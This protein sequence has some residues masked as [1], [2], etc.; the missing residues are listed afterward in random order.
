MFGHNMLINAVAF[1]SDGATLAASAGDAAIRSDAN[2]I[3]IYMDLATAQRARGIRIDWVDSVQGSGLSIDNPNAPAAVKSLTV[4]E[5][6]ARL[7][8]G[9][10]TVID[11]RP[12]AERGQAALMQPFRTLDEGVEPL[13]QLAKDTLLAFLCH[14]GERSARV[15]AHFRGQGF[16]KVYNVAGGIDAWSREIDPS[17]PRY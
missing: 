2:G 5:L 6:K 16:D 1:S 15:A 4:Q 12:A 9:D 8:A 14:S 10:I 3:A 7:D 13:L 17:V 11:V